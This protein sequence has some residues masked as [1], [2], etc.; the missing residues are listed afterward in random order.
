VA[1]TTWDAGNKSATETL[2]GGNL[3]ATSS[4][5]GTVAATRT[6]TGKAYFEVTPALVGLV[7]M[8]S[9][10]RAGNTASLKSAAADFTFTPPSGFAAWD[11]STGAFQSAGPNITLSNAGATA[12]GTGSA[13]GTVHITGQWYFEVNVD[14]LSIINWSC[15]EAGVG[16]GS[17]SVAA[18]DLTHNG[19]LSAGF[20][21]DGLLAYN[22][23]SLGVTLGGPA[24]ND[25]YC[26]AIDIDNNRL[27]IRRNNGNWNNSASANPATGTGG[28][29]L[30]GL[31][32]GLGTIAV[33]LVNRGYNMASGTILG[34]NNNG[35]G[36]KSTGA[37]VLNNVTLT[38]LASYASNDVVGVAVDIANCLI[39]FRVG[40]GNWNNSAGADPAT[41]AGGIDYSG[42]A[43]SALL[44]AAGGSAS[45]LSLTGAFTT[46]TNTPPSGFITVDTCQATAWNSDTGKSATYSTIGGVAASPVVTVVP[47]RSSFQMGRGMGSGTF[48]VP[49]AA[50][51]PPGQVASAYS[52]TITVQGGTLPYS[53]AISSGSAPPG[54]SLDGSSGV[55]SGTPTT[56]GSYSFTVQVTDS[57]G[58]TGST[59]FSIAITL[60]G[61]SGNSGYSN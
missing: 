24:V 34:S 58:V 31:S 25:R 47:A 33:G 3:V 43:L 27:W 35:I 13:I 40:T 48:V 7:P 18:T 54:L 29:T 44:P 52:E 45:A 42:M 32:Q 28:L 41:G 38:S 15:W 19:T 37:V 22:S 21:A 2:T 8:V 56:V 59:P 39:W 51:L 11:S 14:A 46:F 10:T 55:I 1:A 17:V 12:T 30:A 23:S 57:N 50:I 9:F 36:Y 49:V 53:F 60:P 4:G 20:Q 61:D 26:I 16:L 6:L 5:L